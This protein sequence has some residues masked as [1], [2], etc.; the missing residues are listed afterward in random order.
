MDCGREFHREKKLTTWLLKCKVRPWFLK[1]VKRKTSLSVNANRQVG[2][3]TSSEPAAGHRQPSCLS[4][5]T[6]PSTTFLAP[7]R[8]RSLLGRVYVI[9]MV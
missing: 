9:S 3:Q 5:V 1:R 4:F 7:A 8:E 2:I 6:S